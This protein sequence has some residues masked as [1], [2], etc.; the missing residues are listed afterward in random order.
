MQE[1]ICFYFRS[2]SGTTVSSAAHTG[3]YIPVT[4]F[5]NLRASMPALT[6]AG[7]STSALAS[8]SSAP[9]VS[10][11]R[12][13]SSLLSSS[14]KQSFLASVMSSAKPFTSSLG[15]GG[16]SGQGSQGSQGSRILG[17]KLF[18]RPRSKSQ[19]RTLA[20]SAWTP[21]V[22]ASRV[23]SAALRKPSPGHFLQHISLDR[24]RG[25][26]RKRVRP[27]KYDLG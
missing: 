26:V 5:N 16:S 10:A 1:G 7:G 23:T 3:I 15:G 25:E 18:H 27:S 21:Q 12:S 2:S 11:A 22:S 20:A 4:A 19:S 24:Q 8:G 17:K 9:T 6:T 14:A 13:T